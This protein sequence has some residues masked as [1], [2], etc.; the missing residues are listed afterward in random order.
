MQGGTWHC[1]K[2]TVNKMVNT[3]GGQQTYVFP[4]HREFDGESGIRNCPPLQG[5]RRALGIFLV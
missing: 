2:V 4:C 3:D 1:G 5:C